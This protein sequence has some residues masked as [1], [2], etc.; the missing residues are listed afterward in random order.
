MY[1]HV[2]ELHALLAGARVGG[3]YV[4][5]GHSYGGRIA[6]VYA[7][8]YPREVAGMVLIDPAGWMTIHAFPRSI[9]RSVRQN[10]V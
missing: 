1:Q 2:R 8:T 9:T 5:V 7:K 10:D 3:P 4:L 6:R